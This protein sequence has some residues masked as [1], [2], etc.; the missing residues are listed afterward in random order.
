MTDD[1]AA[2]FSLDNLYDAVEAAGSPVPGAAG[3]QVSVSVFE[4][5]VDAPAA[6]LAAG[7]AA[8]DAAKVE[9]FG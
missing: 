1:D 6:P 5:S 9:T 2:D 7:G 3:K 8:P 4:A